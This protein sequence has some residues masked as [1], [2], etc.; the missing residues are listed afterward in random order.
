MTIYTKTIASMNCLKQDQSMTDVVYQINWCL[1]GTSDVN[2]V[3]S[4]A[5]IT[6]VPLPTTSFIPYD[7]LTESQVMAWIDEY[8]TQKSLDDAM[9]IIESDLQIAANTTVQPLPWAS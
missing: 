4:Q 9:A 3:S 5:M 6:N 7:Q 8:T 2:F 1:T